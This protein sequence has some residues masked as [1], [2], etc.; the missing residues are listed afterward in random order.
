VS[1]AAADAPRTDRTEGDEIRLALLDAAASVFA[2][3]GYDGTKIQD[4]V[5]RAGLSTGAVYGRFSSKDELLREA[6]ITHATPQARRLEEGVTRVAELIERIG[7]NTTPELRESEA[8]LLEAYVAA[9]RH[10]EIAD[11]IAEANRRWRQKVTLLAEAARADGSLREDVDE[12]AVMFLVRV[13]RLGLL[14]HR[15]S[16]LPEPEAGPWTDLVTH[17]VASLGD[18]SLAGGNE[19]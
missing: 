18:P 9:R 5:K 1:T 4:I 15:A 8:L 6:V 10:P 19:S 13:L 3:R 16:G 2:E 11:A 17:V 14:L 12:Q 7:A